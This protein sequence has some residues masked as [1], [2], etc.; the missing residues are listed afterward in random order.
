[1][2]PRA[3]AGPLAA[4]LRGDQDLRRVPVPPRQGLGDQ[5]LVVADLVGVDVVGVGG[6]DQ[7]HAGVQRGQ[8][9]GGRPFA[10]R[11]PLDRHRHATEA[12]GA[13]LKISDGP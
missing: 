5:D 2:R 7:R 9:R 13:D 11:T 10:V 4:A 1:V 8:D 3:V 12:D 6:V